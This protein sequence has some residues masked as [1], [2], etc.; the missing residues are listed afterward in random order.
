MLLEKVIYLTQQVVFYQYRRQ[1][2]QVKFRDCLLHIISQ[3][4]Q[5]FVPKK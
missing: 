4:F 5:K 1:H 2:I 3:R